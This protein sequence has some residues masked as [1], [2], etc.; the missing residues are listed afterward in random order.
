MALL[1]SQTG[2]E[3]VKA[4]LNILIVRDFPLLDTSVFRFEIIVLAFN[5]FHDR[6]SFVLTTR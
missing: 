1:S 4:D 2:R 3:I 5:P 6:I